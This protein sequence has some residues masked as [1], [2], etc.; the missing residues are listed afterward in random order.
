MVT[1]K[2]KNS[3]DLPWDPNVLG[4]LSGI[5]FYIAQKDLL[6]VYMGEQMLNILVTQFWL[7]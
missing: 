2:I 6:E 1:T 7:M 5:P 4:L 3:I